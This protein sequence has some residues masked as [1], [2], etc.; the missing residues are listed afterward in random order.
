M[1]E[2]LGR[3]L[4][5]IIIHLL[6][7]YRLQAQEITIKGGFVED[8]ILIGNDVQYWIS[9]TYPSNLEV[10]FPDSL[11]DYTPFEYTSKLYFDS[12]L[13][14]NGSIY[15]ST[16]YFVQSFEIDLVQY[17]QLP[18]I[19]LNGQDSTVINSPLDSIYLT[20]LAP[21]VSDSTKLKEN[22]DY[23]AVSTQFNYPLMYYILGGFLL[24]LLILGIIFGKKIIK[25]FKLRRIK[26]QYLKFNEQF[27]DYIK[28][29]KVDPDPKLAERTLIL[30]K[31]YQEGLDRV[32]F[33]VLTTKE[34]LKESFTQELE[35]PLKSIDRV[36]YGNRVQED[37]YQ[38]FNQME[39][40][41]QDRYSKKVEEI[42][43]G[44]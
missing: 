43:N 23:Q 31:K 32:P 42:K 3:I 14:D 17:M 7:S 34:I 39:D 21:V 33:S 35:K 20:E 38:E 2:G 15:D 9:A 37:V 19:V 18:A 11:Y 25:W 16:I 36:V 10:I 6:F 5:S 41:T 4:L 28:R 40:F 26:K 8:S 24:L 27:S 30:W 44:K 1:R 13:L 12:E 29:L 22:L